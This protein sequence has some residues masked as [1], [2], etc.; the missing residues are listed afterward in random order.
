MTNITNKHRGQTEPKEQIR[1]TGNIW[2]RKQT[3][4]ARGTEQV[5]QAGQT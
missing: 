3:R 5:G 1:H 2:Q 4:E